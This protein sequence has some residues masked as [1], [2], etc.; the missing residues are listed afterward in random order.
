MISD[1]PTHH[2]YPSENSNRTGPNVILTPTEAQLNFENGKMVREMGIFRT[3]GDWIGFESKSV[4]M[5]RNTVAQSVHYQDKLISY[6]DKNTSLE[7]LQNIEVSDL[8]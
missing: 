6:S 8:Y 5:G 2:V 7:A 3:V 4:T 1:S